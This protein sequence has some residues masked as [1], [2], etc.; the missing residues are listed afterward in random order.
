[1][2]TAIIQDITTAKILQFGYL[3]DIALSELE[4]NKQLSL[5]DK[6][7]NVIDLPEL[8]VEDYFVKA[9]YCLVRVK[10]AEDTSVYFSETESEKAA[11]L[12]YLSSII[13]KRKQAASTDTSYT[14]R[15]FEKGINK[16]AQKVGEEAVELVIEAKDDNKDLFLGEAADLLFHFLVLLEAKNIRLEEVIAVLQSRHK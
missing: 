5:L 14:A 7:E 12:D 10:A 15:L 4:S 3:T 1:M 8:T 2:K 9:D 6:E 16:V 11:F 13:A